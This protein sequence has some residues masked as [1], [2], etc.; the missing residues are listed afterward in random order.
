MFCVEGSELNLL[1]MCSQPMMVDFTD[2][3]LDAMKRGDHVSFGKCI[4]AGSE[5]V[6]MYSQTFT[7]LCLNGIEPW[8]ILEEDARRRL[9]DR[10]RSARSGWTRVKELSPSG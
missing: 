2:F 6:R 4:E 9:R 5:T 7:G 1:A 8:R 3:L 10:C